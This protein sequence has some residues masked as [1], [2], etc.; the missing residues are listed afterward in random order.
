M[1]LNSADTHAELAGDLFI[2]EAI[3]YQYKNLALAI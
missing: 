3:G 2:E 1:R